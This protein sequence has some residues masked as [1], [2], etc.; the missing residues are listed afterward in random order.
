[1]ALVVVWVGAIWVLVMVEEVVTWVLLHSVG[2][3]PSLKGSIGG[4]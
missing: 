2:D 3:V 1:M 4:A